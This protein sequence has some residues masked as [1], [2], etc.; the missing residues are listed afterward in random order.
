M[1]QCYVEAT[2]G[3]ASVPIGGT[4]LVSSVLEDNHQ[5]RDVVHRASIVRLQGDTFSTK[6]WLVQPVPDVRDGFLVG[7]GIPQTIGGQNQEHWSV[8]QEGYWLE[9]RGHTYMTVTHR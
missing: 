4:D 8:E 9:L 2:I 1:G 7:E 6:V 3:F 5:H